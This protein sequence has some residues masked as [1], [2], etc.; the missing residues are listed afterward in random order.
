MGWINSV[1]FYSA[2][3]PMLY[4]I[5][6]PELPT[7]VL[8][9]AVPKAQRY[10]PVSWD[11]VVSGVSMGLLLPGQAFLVGLPHQP[12]TQPTQDCT[13]IA[14]QP[15]SERSLNFKMWVS[16]ENEEPETRLRRG[17][18]TRTLTSHCLSAK[19]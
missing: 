13:C 16:W 5:R 19:R 9:A 18:L 4:K 15:G 7:E 17:A 12:L 2:T 6:F 14:S 10:S 11:S 8:C 3:S 1:M